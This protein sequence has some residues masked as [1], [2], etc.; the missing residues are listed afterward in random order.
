[1]FKKYIYGVLLAITAGLGIIFLNNKI[2]AEGS[3]GGSG[4]PGTVK[5]DNPL[6]ETS[7]IKI[8]SNILDWLIIY[9]IPIL[10]LMILI[11]GFQILTAKDS[12][13]K[14][15]SGKKT[16]MFAVVGFVI[17]LISK[18]IALIILNIIG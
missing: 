13:E 2:L 7:I 5:L 10:A 3:P 11:G 1:M 16:I 6:G 9:S 17:I 4:K 14:V 12:P 8:I 15:T 18:G